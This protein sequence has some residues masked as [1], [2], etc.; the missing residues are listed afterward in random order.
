MMA[1]TEI[2]LSVTPYV[3]F[4]EFI[5]VP[6]NQQSWTLETAA[7][8]RS[9]S[10]D[11]VYTGFSYLDGDF[12]FSK[13]R[14]N[15]DEGEYGY[16]DFSTFSSNV[17]LGESSNFSVEEAGFYQIIADVSTGT[18]TLTPTVW[19]ILGTATSAQWEGGDALD[20]TWNAADDSWNITTD[21]Q[22]GELKFVA[23]KSWDINLGGTVDNLSFDGD[24]LSID[25]DGNYTI[26]LYLTRSASENMY[27]TITKN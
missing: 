21:L 18:L 26:N 13:S 5:Y 17:V 23:N 7:A 9:P 4:N 14:V 1:S 24:N 8:L 25:E 3:D 6:G 10:F 19:G 12:K 11:G 22:V 16:N 20:M 2:T 27:C 15:W